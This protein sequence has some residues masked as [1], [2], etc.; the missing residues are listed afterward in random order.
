VECRTPRVHE[1]QTG[2]GHAMKTHMIAVIEGWAE[3]SSLLQYSG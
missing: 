2:G 3:M 1:S